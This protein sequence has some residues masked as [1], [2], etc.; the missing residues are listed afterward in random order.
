MLPRNIKFEPISVGCEGYEN[1]KDKWILNG[2]CQVQYKL[3]T[4]IPKTK[5]SMPV[6][7]T[8]TM[9]DMV[10]F[11]MCVSTFM[12]MFEYIPGS[13][14]FVLGV[15]CMSLLSGDGDNYD[16]NS[17]DDWCGTSNR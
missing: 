6:N 7:K 1:V 14:A 16:Y 4:K 13:F 8:Y 15:L 17:D 12:F 9:W 11:L 3:R 10:M 5:K 2:S